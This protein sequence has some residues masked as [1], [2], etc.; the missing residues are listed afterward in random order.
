MTETATAPLDLRSNPE[1]QTR[2]VP[3][4]DTAHCLVIDDFLL[5]PAAAVAWAARERDRF[6]TQER[7]YPGEV[8]PLDERQAEP[9]RAMVRRRLSRE[10]GFLRGDI[11]LQLQFSLTTLQPEAFTW[12]QRLPH[13]D[14]R[15]APDR[16]N[17]ATVLYLFDDPDLGGTAFYRWRDPDYWR[18]MSEAQRD[19]PA[20]GLAELRERF[21]LFRAPPAYPTGSNEVVEC[22]AHVPARYNRLIAYP[23]ELPHSAR[24]EHPERLVPDP[25]RGRLTLNGFA[26]VRLR[27]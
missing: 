21:E 24:I 15:L 12:I 11:E 3:V 6:E 23:G 20:A 26:S 22:L 4:G 16:S 13:A 7:A 8:L 14:P 5:D 19:D 17:I 2:R 27:P 18:A 25:A 1:A 10:F 9:I